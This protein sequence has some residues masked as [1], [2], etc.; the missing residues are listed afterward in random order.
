MTKQFL[1]RFVIQ[2]IFTDESAQILE[3]DP[4]VEMEVVTHVGK[5]DSN[6]PTIRVPRRL[7]C[8][9]PSNGWSVRSRVQ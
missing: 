3:Q 9:I 1:P 6:A 2:N 5:F 4:L 7:P 8:M